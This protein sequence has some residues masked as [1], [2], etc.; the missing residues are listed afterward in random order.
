MSDKNSYFSTAFNDYKF[1]DGNTIYVDR[2]FNGE[3]VE[4]QSYTTITD[5]TE[6][7]FTLSQVGLHKFVVRDLAGRT[8]T[9]GTGTTTANALQIYLVNQILFEVNDASP[10]NN[11]IFNN[12]IK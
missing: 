2:Y 6:A 5:T 11:Q 9:F 10:I 8:Q 12:K 3:L 1:V 4:T 7:K